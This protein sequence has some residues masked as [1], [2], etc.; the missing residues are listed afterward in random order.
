MNPV[1][2]LQKNMHSAVVITISHR[3]APPR[4]NPEM[5]RAFFIV[6]PSKWAVRKL[7]ATAAVPKASVQRQSHRER[8]ETV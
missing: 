7:F 6:R 3:A 2:L 1:L 4:A 8:P 5:M